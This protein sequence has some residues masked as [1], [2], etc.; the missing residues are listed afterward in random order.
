MKQS[1][2]PLDIAAI[3]AELRKRKES[4]PSKQEMAAMLAELRWEIQK[5]EIAM[6]AVL[7]LSAIYFAVLLAILLKR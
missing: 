6:F 5:T 3:L 7:G 2:T 4:P 1:P